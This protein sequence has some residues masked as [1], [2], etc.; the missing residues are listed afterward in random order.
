MRRHQTPA[1]TAAV[2]PEP[3]RRRRRFLGF[4]KARAIGAVGMVLAASLALVGIEATPAHAVT[5]CGPWHYIAFGQTGLNL[6][7]EDDN[8]LY[9]TGRANQ[10][11]WNQQVQ[12]CRDPDWGANHYAIRS[13]R[14]GK[15]WSSFMADLDRGRI[16][17]CSTRVFDPQELF[18]ITDFDG[19]FFLIKS[20]GKNRFLNGSTMPVTLGGARENGTNL[21]LISPRD[22]R[23]W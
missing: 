19:N 12:F 8:Y 20:V 7:P 4:R 9:A 22:L 17:S 18:E 10:D 23:Y 13:N 14:G 6:K 11:F 3:V 21:Y 15:Y 2:S 5:T 16:C 1:K